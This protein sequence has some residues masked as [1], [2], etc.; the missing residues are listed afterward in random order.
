M[1][2]LDVWGLLL[3]FPSLDINKSQLFLSLLQQ[4]SLFEL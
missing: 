3:A 4:P 1:W 2:Y